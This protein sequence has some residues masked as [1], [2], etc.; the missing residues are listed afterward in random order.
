L[1]ESLREGNIKIDI[2]ETGWE[3]AD[4]I[5]LTQKKGPVAGSRE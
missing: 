5:N 3:D 4:W 1:S 2:K